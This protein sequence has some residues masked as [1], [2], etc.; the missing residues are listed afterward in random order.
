M[1]SFFRTVHQELDDD[2]FGVPN[3]CPVR[4]V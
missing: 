1:A 2:Y 4:D 3:D